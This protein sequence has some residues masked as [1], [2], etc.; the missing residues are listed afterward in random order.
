LAVE[1]S[2]PERLDVS[3]REVLG[4]ILIHTSVVEVAEYLHEP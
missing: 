2:D 1:S 4:H 3:W